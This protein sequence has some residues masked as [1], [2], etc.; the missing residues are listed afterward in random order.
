MFFKGW[1]SHGIGQFVLRSAK[2]L[3]FEKA[4]VPVK[5]WQFMLII[6]PKLKFKVE[7]ST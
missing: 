3:K 4:G 6:F 5:G 1:E 2:V 7:H